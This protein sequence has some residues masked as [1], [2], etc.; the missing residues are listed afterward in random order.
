M[1]DNTIY[2][3]SECS[4][5]I[6]K[7]S[8]NQYFNIHIQSF[9]RLSYFSALSWKDKSLMLCQQDFFSLCFVL[10]ITYLTT[11][12]AFHHLCWQL[13]LVESKFV[14]HLYANVCLVTRKC[15]YRLLIW[16]RV[17]V[18]TPATHF[19]FLHIICHRHTSSDRWLGYLRALM[20]AMVSSESSFWSSLVIFGI[21]FR[22]SF[23]NIT[24]LFI[25]YLKIQI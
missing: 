18:S 22:N 23:S 19:R 11:R 9:C 7:R 4:L 14:L 21:S 13:L 12:S 2:Q 20:N 24:D 8:P 5:E 16:P 1:E 6:S 10:L 17:E 25:R 3:W 15:V